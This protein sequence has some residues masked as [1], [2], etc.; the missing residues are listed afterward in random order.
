MMN[1][2]TLMEWNPWWEQKT[3]FDLVER[4]LEKEL[5]KWIGRKEIIGI[6]G[7]R[8]SGKTSLMKLIIKHLLHSTEPKNILFIKA[9]DD[10]IEKKNLISSVIE[11]YKELLNPMG[12]L[13]IFIDEIQEVPEWENTL[14]RIYDLE[15][16]VKFFISGSNFSILRE[17]L[18]YK[19]SGRI[20]YFELYP[21]SFKEFIRL[22]MGLKAPYPVSKKQE[23]KHYFMRYFEGGGFP[24]VAIENNEEK[25]KQ[26]LQFY[27]DT[28]IYR[29][30]IKRREIR[31]AAKMERMIDYFLQNIATPINFSNVAKNVSLSTDS[32]VEY[33]RYLEEA[34]LVFSVPLF[35]FSVKKQEINPKK[36]YCV[37][38]GIRNVKGFR[39]SDDYGRLAE[40]LVFIE[41][42]RR[43]SAKP[44]SRIFYWWGDGEVDF[45]VKDGIKVKEVVQVCWDIEKEETRDREVKAM[46]RAMKEFR[47]KESFVIT[48]NKEGEE[49]IDGRK[50]KYRALWKWLLDI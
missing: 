19:L 31:N 33:V 2:E 29:D 37:D 44:L 22:K 12:R 18:S 7:V 5:I 23:I 8:R 49:T 15:P 20:A 4:D 9:D 38:T 26:L 40:N 13:F 24:E 14:K 41:L 16:N 11:Q 45:V 36:I 6:L 35:T 25:G 1:R 17:D 46:L 28:I 50:I 27:Y 42:K 21:F 47:L 39:F 34:F 3:A 48:E 30:I 10:R 32:V 43:N